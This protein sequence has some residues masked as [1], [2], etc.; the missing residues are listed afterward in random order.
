MS[1]ATRKKYSPSSKDTC[2]LP[3]NIHLEKKDTPAISEAIHDPFTH[4]NSILL[5]LSDPNKKV[6]RIRTLVFGFIRQIGEKPKFGESIGKL[7]EFIQKNGTDITMD[8]RILD[9]YLK[10]FPN[11]FGCF[12]TSYFSKLFQGC[13]DT[14]SREDDP[15]YT[16]VINNEKAKIRYLMKYISIIMRKIMQAF[17]AALNNEYKLEIKIPDQQQGGDGDSDIQFNSETYNFTKELVRS[18]REDIQFK[19]PVSGQDIAF[20]I[21]LLLTGFGELMILFWLFFCVFMITVASGIYTHAIIIDIFNAVFYS[22]VVLKKLGI[23]FGNFTRKM[24]EK[25]RH[26]RDIAQHAKLPQVYTTTVQSADIKKGIDP[27]A[28]MPE[29]IQHIDPR[30]ISFV[31]DMHK[32][33][34]NDLR[35]Y[36]VKT[37]EDKYRNVTEGEIDDFLMHK[38]KLY[39][40]KLERMNTYAHQLTNV[41]RGKGYG[42]ISQKPKLLHYEE[43][44]YPNIP[45]LA[46]L[47]SYKT[48]E[49][50]DAINELF[51]VSVANHEGKLEQA[52]E[53]DISAFLQ[54]KRPLYVMM[55]NKQYKLPYEIAD[56]TYVKK[57]TG[58]KVAH[59]NDIRNFINGHGELFFRGKDNDYRLIPNPFAIRK[60]L[61]PIIEES[62]GKSHEESPPKSPG[63]STRTNWLHRFIRSKKVQPGLN[64]SNEVPIKTPFRFPRISRK[65]RITPLGGRR[66]KTR[67]TKS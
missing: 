42:A 10:M 46:E 30:G 27:M 54:K 65:S 8:H 50:P 35:K 15:E 45:I 36:Y 32:K 5:E 53:T 25:M 4:E 58:Y 18:I 14:F 6:G 2:E 20:Y 24:K 29:G 64:P 56:T 31:T 48:E 9:A 11:K 7:F 62:P 40:K 16:N 66:K 23:K 12:D 26:K 43:I 21:V 61:S 67:R 63:K 13:K 41:E 3:S 28:D 59:N 38:N 1:S 37:G 19:I 44:E 55:W 57:E 49:V 47:A 39:K 52:I 34:R 60:K 51:E 33:I 22:P 17:V